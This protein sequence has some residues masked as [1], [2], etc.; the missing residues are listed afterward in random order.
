MYNFH[1]IHGWI[2]MFNMIRVIY[3]VAMKTDEACQ[4]L[5]RGCETYRTLNTKGVQLYT[6][7][8]Y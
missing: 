6:N 5:T 2:G 1:T 8:Y 4:V 7:V 3:K